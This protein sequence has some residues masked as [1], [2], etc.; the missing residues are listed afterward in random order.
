MTLTVVKKS[1][2]AAKKTKKA[3]LIKSKK[4]TKKTKKAAL[5]KLLINDTDD[6]REDLVRCLH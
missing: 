1:K 3:A 6:S 2:K 5:I 4:A